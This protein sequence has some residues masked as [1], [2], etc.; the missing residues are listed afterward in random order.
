MVTTGVVAAALG[1]LMGPLKGCGWGNGPCRLPAIS[2][3]VA[4]VAYASSHHV[5][6]RVLL[7]L[8]ARA[9][10]RCGHG[11]VAFLVWLGFGWGGEDATGRVRRWCGAMGQPVDGVGEVEVPAWCS[12]VFLDLCMRYCFAWGHSHAPGVSLPPACWRTVTRC[13][14]SGWSGAVCAGSNL[15]HPNLGLRMEDWTRDVW[16]GGIV[17]CICP[18]QSG[19][20]SSCTVA[21]APRVEGGSGTGLW[22]HVLR[23]RTLL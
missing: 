17:A 23:F 14:G 16:P 15:A 12:G 7:H 8:A 18:S 19:P 6:R 3:L 9:V 10:R 4:H 13:L 5:P 20:S 1:R 21:L 11:P 22:S 2:K